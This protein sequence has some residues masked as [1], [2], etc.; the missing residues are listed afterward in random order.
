M[1][2]WRFDMT[3][4]K[5]RFTV[6]LLFIVL[7]LTS[8]SG[9]ATVEPTATFT[10]TSVPTATS[11]LTP[12]LSPSP[13]PTLTLVPSET[14]I[15]L[16]ASLTGIVSL[17]GDSARPL[18]S[19]VELREAESFDLLAKG[20][21]NT[22]GEYKIED[23]QPG[24]YE[25]WVLITTKSSM[26]SGCGDVRPPD[27]TWKIGVNFEG[28]TALTM[29]NAYLSKAL[30]LVE[31]LQGSGLKAIGFYAVLSAFEIISGIEN[32]F[33]VTLVCE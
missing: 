27:D 2:L 10:A 5:Y 3:K 12:T 30:F 13:T 17:S 4:F 16:P 31:N 24:K 18:V 28:G 6:H 23:I 9:Q 29:E 20:D 1:I 22:K 21:T 15:P 33:D 32:K 11:T 25:L 14:S 26:V 19:V 7:L 8:C